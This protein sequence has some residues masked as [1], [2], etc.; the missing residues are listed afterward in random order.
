MVGG[1]GGQRQHD[2]GQRQ[3]HKWWKENAWTSSSMVVVARW[4]GRP[5]YL[6]SVSTSLMI[7]EILQISHRGISSSG[8]QIIRLFLHLG[9]QTSTNSRLYRFLSRSMTG[10]SVNSDLPVPDTQSEEEATHS[11]REGLSSKQVP[12]DVRGNTEKHED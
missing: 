12:N 8:R 4:K 10:L 6:P 5:Q 1:S 2:H 7:M 9:Q 11:G 3:G